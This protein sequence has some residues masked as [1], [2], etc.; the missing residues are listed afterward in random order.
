MGGGCSLP[1][2]K[3]RGGGQVLAVLN[4]VGGEEGH[5]MF[6]GKIFLL[7]RE[8][9]VLAILKGGGGGK[10]I[11]PFKRVGAKRFTPF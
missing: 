1:L 2:Q 8:L 4:G 6:C 11:P 7:I 9:E 3:K 5:T 10:Q